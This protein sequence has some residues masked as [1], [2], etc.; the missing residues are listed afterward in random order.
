[1]PARR[2][3]RR[4]KMWRYVGEMREIA[5]AF[6]AAGLPSGFHNAAAEVSERLACFKDQSEPPLT[7]ATVL[8]QLRSSKL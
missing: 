1:M 4:A 8:E 5:E 2:R 7:V 3:R 6:Q